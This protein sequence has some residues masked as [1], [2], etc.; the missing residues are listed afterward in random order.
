MIVFGIVAAVFTV[1]ALWVLLPPLLRVRDKEEISRQGLNVTVYRDQL[2]ELENDLVNGLINQKELEQAKQEIESSLLQD[3]AVPD[4]QFKSVANSSTTTA[5]VI[6]LFVPL[7]AVFLYFELGAPKSLSGEEISASGLQFQTQDQL[8]EIVQDLRKAVAD[9]PD[10]GETWTVLA[11][12]HLMLG[13]FPQAVGAFKEA[14]KIT[15]PDAQFFADLS[16][17]TAMARGGNM[18]GEPV[19]L[20]R[21]AIELDPNNEKALWLFGT[22]AFESGDLEAAL[23]PWRR[24]LG[25]MPSDTESATTMFDNIKQVEAMLANVKANTDKARLSPGQGRVTGTITIADEL[26]AELTADAVIFIFAV[27]A[28][29]AA[30]EAKVPLAAM[31]AT[32]AELPLTFALDDSM[33]M[34]PAMRLSTVNDVVLTA[35]V[36]KS[37]DAIAASGDLQ[38]IL[39]GV[40]VGSSDNQLVINT[41][42]P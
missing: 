12:A 16:D 39:E 5:V 2:Q 33:A 21:K 35:R 7:F 28:E 41:R 10:D 31:R 6:A 9:A 34:I 4:A 8:K 26:K 23:V 14:E 29:G 1:V 32:L 40:K 27:A 37:G 19:S 30:K 22:A 24:L 38:G 36:S 17:A 18:Q 25:L 20:L 13:E 42:V 3:V 15:T 11:R